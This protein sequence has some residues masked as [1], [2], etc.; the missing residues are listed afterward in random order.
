MRELGTYIGTLYGIL[1]LFSLIAIFVFDHYERK[2]GGPWSNALLSAMI[3][4]PPTL[5]A[6]FGYAVG[7]YCRDRGRRTALPQ[8]LCAVMGAAFSGAMA[9]GIYLL[10]ETVPGGVSVVALYFFIVGTMAAWTYVAWKGVSAR[11]A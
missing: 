8:Y 10:M 5:V 3:M 7:A 9:F 2:F 6:G 4:L 1:N 11:A